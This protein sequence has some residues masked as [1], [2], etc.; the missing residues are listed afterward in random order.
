M[1]ENN[2]HFL[3]LKITKKFANL[4]WLNLGTESDLSTVWFSTV[5]ERQHFL[6]RKISKIA[7]KVITDR[8]KKVMTCGRGVSKIAKKGLMYFM[9]GPS[10][11]ILIVL[12]WAIH[13]FAATCRI[14]A[15]ANCQGQPL[16][17]IYVPF[18]T[19]KSPFLWPLN[20]LTGSKYT[21]SLCFE[22]CSKISYS[23]I[24]EDFLT[25]I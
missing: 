16:L 13:F 5:K 8:Y 9:D 17:A 1:T 14:A 3:I 21:T 10:I 15:E 6:G 12:C 24:V 7:E 11:R 20:W 23:S 2:V 19:K 22:V 25:E 18:P 4:W